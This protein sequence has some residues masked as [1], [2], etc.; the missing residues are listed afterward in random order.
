MLDSLSNMDQPLGRAV[1]NWN[2]IEECEMILKGE[3]ISDLIE[4]TETLAALILVNS[5]LYNNNDLALAEI[6]KNILN[7]SA[8]KIFY[9]MIS[10]QGGDMSNQDELKLAKTL[11]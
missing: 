6:R 4:L 5:G 7:G 2:E 3:Q 8:L 11:L 9:E 1:G 10:A